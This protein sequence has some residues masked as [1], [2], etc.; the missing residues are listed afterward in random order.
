[1]LYYLASCVATSMFCCCVAVHNIR[2][3]LYKLRMILFFLPWQLFSKR[4]RYQPGDGFCYD[5]PTLNNGALSYDK[6]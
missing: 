1:V 4:H 5:Q 2:I 3:I 6:I